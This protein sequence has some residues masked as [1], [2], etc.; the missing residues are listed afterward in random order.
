MSAGTHFRPLGYWLKMLDRLIEDRPSGNGRS[1]YFRLLTSI[2][3]IGRW[4]PTRS[5]SP[6]FS[7]TLRPGGRHDDIHGQTTRS[8]NVGR[9]R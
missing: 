6:E 8:I 3:V 4:S 7:T 2:P 1:S 9:L 5:L